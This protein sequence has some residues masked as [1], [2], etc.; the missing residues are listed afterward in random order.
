MGFGKKSRKASQISLV[1]STQIYH[2]LTQG[3]PENRFT[4]AAPVPSAP[5]T[6]TEI[7][8][9][10]AKVK[11]YTVRDVHQNSIGRIFWA[12]QW[13]L[14]SWVMSRGFLAQG[15]EIWAEVVGIAEEIEE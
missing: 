1:A 3:C 13:V 4:M 11:V 10:T 12:L 8:A 7:E 2:Q 5:R 14:M 6:S 9:A 15:K